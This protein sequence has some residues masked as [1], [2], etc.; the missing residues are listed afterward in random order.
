MYIGLQHFHSYW[1]YLVLITLTV[2]TANALIGTLSKRNYTSLDRRLSLFALI[3]AH[4]QLVVGIILY[5]ISP[6]STSAFAD[7]GASMRDA[8]IRLYAIEHPLVM[9]VSI[10]LITIGYS[11]AKRQT[12]GQA[13]FRT[14]GLT[15]A[16]ALFLVLS[17]IPWAAWFN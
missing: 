17:R 16:I 3:A 10:A 4:I 5:F 15:Y 7:M 8:V 13:K 12:H 2:A 14:V 6:L 1:A 9:I 11:R